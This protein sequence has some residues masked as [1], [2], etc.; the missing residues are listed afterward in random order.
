[1]SLLPGSMPLNHSGTPA[2]RTRSQA[3]MENGPL[4][5]MTPQKPLV[6]HDSRSA[7]ESLPCGTVAFLEEDEGPQVMPKGSSAQKR[8]SGTA[9]KSMPGAAQKMSTPEEPGG[10]CHAG[11]NASEIH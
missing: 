6:T 10:A 4:A 11:T 2:K 1:M 8:G 3:S 7:E 9:T 5:A